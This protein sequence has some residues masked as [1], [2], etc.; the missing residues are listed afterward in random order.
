MHFIHK[1]DGLY[2]GL[3]CH[4]PVDSGWFFLCACVCVCV[5]FTSTE[6][7]ADKTEPC[8]HAFM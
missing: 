8:S 2:V 6:L 3:L 5:R 7:N 4:I 1:V